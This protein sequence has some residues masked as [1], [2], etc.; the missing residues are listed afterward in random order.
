[1][2]NYFKACPHCGN[3]SISSKNGIVCLLLLLFLGGFGG[4]LFYVGKIG[5]A[6][7]RLILLFIMGI[8]LFIHMVIRRIE[9]INII[10]G[11]SNNENGLSLMFFFV[12]FISSVILAIWWIRDLISIIRGKFKDSKG[13]NIK[14]K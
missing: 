14:I 12:C 5:S 4:H 3:S 6:I 9:Y 11:Y 2:E 13:K 7:I 10:N 8:T 1:M